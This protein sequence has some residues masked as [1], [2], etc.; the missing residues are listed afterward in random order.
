MKLRTASVNTRR[1][2]ARSSRFTAAIGEPS[3]GWSTVTPSAAAIADMMS[4][5]SASST[6]S[7]IGFG[8]ALPKRS[9][10]SSTPPRRSLVAPALIR[11]SPEWVSRSR[12]DSW[13]RG[14][15]RETSPRPRRAGEVRSAR[16]RRRI[17]S[18]DRAARIHRAGPTRRGV[19]DPR[20]VVGRVGEHE[21]RHGCRAR[22]VARRRRVARRERRVRASRRA[23]ERALERFAIRREP[24][25]EQA[26][27]LGSAAQRRQR[28]RQQQQHRAGPSTRACAA[29]TAASRARSR[30]HPPPRRARAA[31]G[32]ARG[33]DAGAS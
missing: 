18:K 25:L 1:I 29:T 30:S 3:L 7:V 12:P 4:T 13:D 32:T 17:R 22:A 33:R 8:S 19:R 10:A 9:I 11:K 31:G 14:S 15:C 23:C 16:H 28:G 24:T 21:S 26:R 6:N 20:G 27:F 2:P 5:P